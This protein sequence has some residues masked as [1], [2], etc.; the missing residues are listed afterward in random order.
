MADLENK[1]DDLLG[2]AKEGIGNV[3]NN[4]D[5]ENEGKADQVKSDAKD[6]L[7]AVGDAIEDKSNEVFGGLN[8]NK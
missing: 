4:K 6:K 1:K 7:N 5:L 8:D 2:K 3:T